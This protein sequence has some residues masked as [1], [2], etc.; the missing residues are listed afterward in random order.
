M[1]Y[2]DQLVHSASWVLASEII[3][4]HPKP[5]DLFIGSPG[6]GMYDVL[7]L[8]PKIKKRISRDIKLNRNGTIQIHESGKGH[9]VLF[10]GK[11]EEFLL[12]NS[13]KYIEKLERIYGLPKVTKVPSTT[14][15]TLAYRF[16]ASFVKTWFLEGPKCYVANGMIDTSGYGGG[17]NADLDKFNFDNSLFERQEDDILG[18]PEYK[19]WI[20]CFY[21]ETKDNGHT[22]DKKPLMAIEEKT[23]ELRIIDEKN[24]LNLFDLFVKND[25]SLP[26]VVKKIN[27][28]V[29][30]KEGFSDIYL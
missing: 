14:H 28:M 13:I 17:R 1:E 2:R 27:T 25:R 6:G 19:F 29:R 3:R 23:T 16:I 30:E 26:A 11:W 4:R 24:S 21:P 8:I 22:P 15:R 9:R 5:F 20:I 12:S 7:W 18:A 10:V